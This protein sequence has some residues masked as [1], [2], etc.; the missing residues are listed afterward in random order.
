VLVFNLGI[1][2]GGGPELRRARFPAADRYLDLSLDHQRR[3]IPSDHLGGY[4]LPTNGADNIPLQYL[5]PQQ[6]LTGTRVVSQ[7]ELRRRLQSS[8]RNERTPWYL[9]SNLLRLRPPISHGPQKLTDLLQLIVQ[10]PH[11]VVNSDETGRRG[12]G[13]FRTGHASNGADIV[14]ESLKTFSTS[15]GEVGVPGL[16]PAQKALQE[17]VAAVGPHFA[18]AGTRGRF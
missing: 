17:V 13:R 11:T 12:S 16:A 2:V 7:P 6:S 9:G 3:H 15:F 1:L 18:H 10:C 4:S 14:N 8:K 5:S